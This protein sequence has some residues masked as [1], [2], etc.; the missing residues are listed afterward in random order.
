MHGVKLV[1]NKMPFHCEHSLAIINLAQ[2]FLYSL[3]IYCILLHHLEQHSWN[4]EPSDPSTMNQQEHWGNL[5]WF[6]VGV[7]VVVDV[8]VVIFF[9]VCWAMGPMLSIMTI[10]KVLL[11][12]VLHCERPRQLIALACIGI[13]P[14]PRPDF[15]LHNS[16]LVCIPACCWLKYTQRRAPASRYIVRIRC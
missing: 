8:V 10:Y 5:A 13:V 12:L 3:Y 1:E 2:L 16:T 14:R 7:V 6:V 9:F 15:W 4:G 11:L